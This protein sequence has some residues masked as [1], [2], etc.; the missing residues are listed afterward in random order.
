[1]ALDQARAAIYDTLSKYIKSVK[2]NVDVFAYNSKKFYIVADGAGFGE[3][4]IPLP[5]T[6]NE[7]VLD[8]IGQIGGL[9]V[10]ASKKRIWVAR[11]APDDSIQ[12][13]PVDWNAIT[14]DG[15]VQTNYQLFP[16]DR[17][18]IQ[19]DCLISLDGIVT[20]IVTPMERVFGVT[21][22]GARSIFQLQNMG[23]GALANGGF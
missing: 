3:Q 5:F 11:P 2:L 16:G 15:L 23:R 9:P 17:I 6:G 13:L 14:Q 12:T 21:Y 7:T 18:Y 20:K 22:L 8:A 19:S 1:M 10:V 4:V